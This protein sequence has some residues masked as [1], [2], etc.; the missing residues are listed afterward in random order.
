MITYRGFVIINPYEDSAWFE[1]WPKGEDMQLCLMCASEREGQVFFFP[2]DWDIRTVT[3]RHR[4]HPLVEYSTPFDT[5]EEAK[6]A[7]DGWIPKR[8]QQA[9]QH[10]AFMSWMRQD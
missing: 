1:K 3:D 4:G 6:T 5:V 10:E 7:I 9:I 2:E 8:A